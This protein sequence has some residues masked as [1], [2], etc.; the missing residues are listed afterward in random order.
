MTSETPV[1]SLPLPAETPQHHDKSKGLSLRTNFSWTFIGNI[2]YAASQWGLL[3]LLAKLTTTAIVGQFSLALAITAPIILFTNLQLRAVQATDARREY[4]PGH[5]LAL[6]LLMTVLGVGVVVGVALTGG[7]NADTV[8]VIVLMGA[9]KGVEALSDVLFGLMQQRDRMDYIARSMMIKGVVSLL[10]VSLVVALTHSMIWGT[11]AL[12]LSWAAVLIVYD[13]P[14]VRWM[15]SLGGDLTPREALTPRWNWPT[16]RRLA[17]L[18]LPLG[19][20]MMLISLNAN[21]P[22]YFVERYQSESEL[23]IFSAMA[24]LVI[25]GSN[26]VNALGQSATTRLSR[27]YAEHHASGYLN[28]TAKLL[29][30][31]A[32]LAVGGVV[33]ALIGGQP[34]LSLIYSP[35]YAQQPDVFVL[36]MVAGGLSY[37]ASFAGYAMTAARL[38]RIQ[39][40]L[41]ALTTAVTYAASTLFVPEMGGRGAVWVLIVAGGRAA[42]GQSGDCGLCRVDAAARTGGGLCLSLNVSKFCMFLAHSIAAARRRG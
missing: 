15:A 5:Y 24:Y 34:L 8:W 20:V 21:I 1:E 27:Y 37:I 7:Y 4:H 14:A 40:L 36:V 32:V 3:V 30:V 33:V 10:A 9:A 16:L 23:G 39:T 41:F 17:L 18:A 42:C 26:I 31:G 13:I 35:E 2:V 6:R 25:A 38:F 22:R 19:F 12:L 29:G 28:L 11:L